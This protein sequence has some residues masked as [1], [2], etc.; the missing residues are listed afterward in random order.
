MPFS[1]QRDRINAHINITSFLSMKCE[2]LQILNR[3]MRKALV[4]A[5]F[6]FYI[7]LIFIHFY[8]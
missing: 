7:F 1:L 8:Q 5:N 4:R 2:F 6:E 3:Y